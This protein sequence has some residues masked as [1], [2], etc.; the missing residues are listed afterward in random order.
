MRFFSVSSAPGNGEEDLLDF[1]SSDSGTFTHH[2]ENMI[3]DVGP[4]PSAVLTDRCLIDC[5]FHIVGQGEGSD[6]SNTSLIL[7]H[8]W[9][10]GVLSGQGRKIFP[11]LQAFLHFCFSLGRA[12]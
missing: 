10:I 9:V 4:N 6:V 11:L 3:A 2:A 1:E 12:G 5:R 7:I 8:R